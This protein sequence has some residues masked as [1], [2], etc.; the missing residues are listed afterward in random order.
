M[1]RAFLLGESIDDTMIE[2]VVDHVILPA[3]QHPSC[4]ASTHHSTHEPT[5]G[6][7]PGS[8][9]HKARKTR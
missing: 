8:T 5:T 1:H 2:R 3:V 7:I 9:R 6:L 4:G